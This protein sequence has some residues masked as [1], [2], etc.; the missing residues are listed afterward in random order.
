MGRPWPARWSRV[1]LDASKSAGHGMDKCGLE[2][3]VF[4][5]SRVYPWPL[6]FGA[7]GPLERLTTRHF[8][9]G[10][11]G[12]SAGSVGEAPQRRPYSLR[13][14]TPVV[15]NGRH[16]AAVSCHVTADDVK[17]HPGVQQVRDTA[18]TELVRR[19]DANAGRPAGL[20]DDPV[21][22]ERRDRPV[23]P[24]RARASGVPVPRLED[25][26]SWTGW[27]IRL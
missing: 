9:P 22:L 5:W 24:A 6:I 2:A 12:S 16:D 4:A 20:A 17:R 13:L 3:P 23:Q 21:D 7:S 14:G 26:V 11:G 15:L 18:A 1:V 19:R 27:V 10:L 25:V 8:W